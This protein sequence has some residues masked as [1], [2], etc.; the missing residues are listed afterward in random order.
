[1]GFHSIVTNTEHVWL[2]NLVATKH[3]V[4]M[5]GA[6]TGEAVERDRFLDSLDRTKSMVLVGKGPTLTRRVNRETLRQAIGASSVEDFYICAI[7]DSWVF[8]DEWDFM[9]TVDEHTIP[10]FFHHCQGD[11]KCITHPYLIRFIKSRNERVKVPYQE[12]KAL[13]DDRHRL[14]CCFV[15]QGR[16]SFNLPELET[17]TGGGTALN[18]CKNMGFKRFYLV[19]FGGKGY[20]ELV[21]GGHHAIP[22]ASFVDQETQKMVERNRSKGSSFN[23]N[24]R[25]E[26]LYV[27]F[28]RGIHVEHAKLDSAA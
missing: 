5:K 22:L 2:K 20:S 17:R 8:C 13:D 12:L 24:G 28:S 6:I 3:K 21:T 15:P 7:G 10:H 1:M 19:G 16:P 14:L 18:F 11:Q 23:G 25:L 27:K 9:F 26:K 4:V